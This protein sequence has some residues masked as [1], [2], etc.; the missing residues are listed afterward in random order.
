MKPLFRLRARG[1]DRTRAFVGRPGCSGSVATEFALAVPTVLLI[2][3]GTADF[4]MLATRSAELAAA[5]RIGAEYARSY[6]SDQNAIQNSMRGAVNVAPA[7]VS[8]TSFP[9]S[10]E[11]DDGTPIP[12]ARSCATAGRPAPNR[13]RIKISASQ[14]FSPLVPWT[15]I[16]EMLSASTE[17]RLQ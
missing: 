16:P 13:V 1:A 3:A 2:A 15:G 8:P 14:A 9:Q 7:L 4:G 17:L 10:C 6:P 12:C 5:T 11:C